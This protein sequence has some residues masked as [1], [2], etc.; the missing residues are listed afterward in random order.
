MFQTFSRYYSCSSDSLIDY[1]NLPS[2]NFL[3]ALGI[4]ILILYF[5]I[6]TN[7]DF[8]NDEGCWEPPTK[9]W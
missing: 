4:L 8:Q 3:D 7:K 1:R 5:V 9:I 2:C 6:T